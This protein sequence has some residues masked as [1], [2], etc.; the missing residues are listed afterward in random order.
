MTVFLAS[1]LLLAGCGSDKGEETDKKTAAPEVTK[2]KVASV[3]PLMTDMLDIAKPLLVKDGIEM[4]IVVLSDNI[5]PNS[6]L[7]NEEVDANFF[8]HPQYMEMFN[9]ENDASLVMIQPIYHAT[10]GAYSL[11]HD[12]LDDLPDGAKVAVPNDP[13]N[14]ARAL[15]L[16]EK[17]DLITLKE[18]VGLEATTKDIIENPK[19]LKFVEVD[20]LMLARSIEDVDLVIMLPAYAAPLGLTPSKDSLIDEGESEFPI[21]L[22]ARENNKDSEAIQKLAEHLSGS[23]I[24]KFLEENYAETTTPAF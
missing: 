16:L 4:E 1:A 12:S 10:L 21:S 24:R 2:I 3:I 11:I 22:V 8:Q 18:G 20:L 13:S 19:K 7:A 6:A 15:Q 23:E 9:E 5:Q 14:L 17:S